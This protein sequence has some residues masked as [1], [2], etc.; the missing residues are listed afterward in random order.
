VLFKCQRSLWDNKEIVEEGVERK[1]KKVIKKAKV[2]VE[3]EVRKGVKKEE[4][5]PITYTKHNS[6]IT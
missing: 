3:E 1:L 5:N 6:Y 2:E 4:T